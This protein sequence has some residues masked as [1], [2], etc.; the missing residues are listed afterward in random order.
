MF[1]AL[2]HLLL[3]VIVCCAVLQDGNSD[4]LTAAMYTLADRYLLLSPEQFAA[5]GTLA[6]LGTHSIPALLARENNA[7]RA[8]LNF[9]LHAIYPPPSPDQVATKVGAYQQWGLLCWD[10]L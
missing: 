1:P 9:L 8:A 4:E 5:T 3:L 6:A 7:L 2:G 10:H